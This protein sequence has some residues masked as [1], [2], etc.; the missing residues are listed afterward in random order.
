MNRLN[1]KCLQYL[2]IYSTFINFIDCNIHISVE[3]HQKISI[4][5]FHHNENDYFILE[6]PKYLEI[7][8]GTN[9]KFRCTSDRETKWLFNRKEVNLIKFKI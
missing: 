1:L 6:T 4:E 5:Y 8:N 2:L 9:L 3:H 7:K